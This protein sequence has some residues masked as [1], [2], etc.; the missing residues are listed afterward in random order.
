MSDQLFGNS[1]TEIPAT[2]GFTAPPTDSQVSGI[3]SGI[4][5]GDSGVVSV[6]INTLNST[7]VQNIQNGNNF[8]SNSN[9][10]N[11][12]PNYIL[13]GIERQV[14]E[15]SEKLRENFL[16]F[17]E[18]YRESS[19]S[20]SVNDPSGLTTTSS[21]LGTSEMLLSTTQGSEPPLFSENNPL[22]RQQLSEI[23]NEGLNTIYVDFNHL[24]RF[25]DVLAN[26]IAENFYR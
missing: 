22:Y 4:T 10:S 3:Y 2:P 7:N 14:D 20:N 9:S 23:R 13:G 17:L 12:R 1:E 24:Y 19:S 8:F 11:H 21:T 15:T 6:T 18:R 16:A 5:V 26:A 25:D